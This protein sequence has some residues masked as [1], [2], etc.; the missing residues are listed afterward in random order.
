MGSRRLCSI[1]LKIDLE[2]QQEDGSSDVA[3]RKMPHCLLTSG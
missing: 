1:L 3:T 2:G